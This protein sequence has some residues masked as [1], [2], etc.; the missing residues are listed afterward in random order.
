MSTLPVLRSAN[1]A[2]NLPVN[3]IAQTTK[4]YN[5]VILFFFLSQTGSITEKEMDPSFWFIFISKT[6]LFDKSRAAPQFKKAQTFSD[7]FTIFNYFRCLNCSTSTNSILKM[8]SNTT[9]MKERICYICCVVTVGMLEIFQARIWYDCLQRSRPSLLMLPKI[10]T[11][12]NTN[13]S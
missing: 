13:E 1:N 12:G 10:A 3:T 4:H 8:K 6:L 7:D 5:S 11:G 9:F 2:I